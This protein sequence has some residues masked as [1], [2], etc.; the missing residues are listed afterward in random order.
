MRCGSSPGT[1]HPLRGGIGRVA[2]LT[3][4][5]MLHDIGN[6]LDGRGT[7]L[8]VTLMD[9]CRLF[10]EVCLDQIRYVRELLDPAESQRRMEL[11]VRD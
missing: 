8:Q 9:F 4:H 10:L 7:V 5:V 2:R 1:G 6:H 11:D 3:S